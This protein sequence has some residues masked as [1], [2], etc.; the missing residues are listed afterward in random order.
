MP[1]SFESVSMEKLFSRA[2]IALAAIG[3]TFGAA[4]A[5]ADDAA[6]DY[7]QGIL[8]EAEPI[9]GETDEVVMFEGIAEFVDKYV[10]MRRVGLFTLGQY[11]RRVTAGQRAE[12][13]PLFKQYATQI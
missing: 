1:V 6:E 11:A 9:L 12:F 4:P 5:N 2:V 7:I 3:L 8:D 13:L 10:D